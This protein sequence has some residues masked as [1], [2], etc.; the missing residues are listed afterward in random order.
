MK[1]WYMNQKHILKDKGSTHNSDR[2]GKSASQSGIIP[3]SELFY[4]NLVVYH[5]TIAP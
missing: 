3:D 1:Y 5:N 4:K 2:D